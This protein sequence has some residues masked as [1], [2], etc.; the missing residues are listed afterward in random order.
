MLRAAGELGLRVPEDLSVV[1]FDGADLPWLGATLTTVV[2]PT[3]RKGQLA[4]RAALELIAG[5]SPSDVVLP[6]SLR[7]GTTSG[8][9]PG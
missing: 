3:A 5:G 8:P 4:A 1:G 2:Q 9:P 7:I 6:V